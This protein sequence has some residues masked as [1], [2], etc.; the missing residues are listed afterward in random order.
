MAARYALQPKCCVM[1]KW[2]SGQAG[3]GVRVLASLSNLLSVLSSLHSCLCPC[4]F[5]VQARA[6]EAVKKRLP[7]KPVEGA[8]RGLRLQPDA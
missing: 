5:A 3:M 4:A 8:Q 7:I 2:S 6:E 1:V